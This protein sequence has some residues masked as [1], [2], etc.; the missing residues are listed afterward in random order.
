MT[1]VALGVI[2]LMLLLLLLL[3]L[4]RYS[5]P[6]EAR[7]RAD[8][9]VAGKAWSKHLLRNR[10]IVVSNFHGMLKNVLVCPHCHRRSVT[11]DPFSMLSLPIPHQK[12]K[13]F[14]V[15]VGALLWLAVPRVLHTSCLLPLD[16]VFVRCFTLIGPPC[17]GSMS[18]QRRCSPC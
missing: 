18:R 15:S 17:L 11:F 12:F 9:V 13:S 10:S 6:Q 16:C 5:S 8:A 3:L 2:L 4:L 14:D 7:G 1:I